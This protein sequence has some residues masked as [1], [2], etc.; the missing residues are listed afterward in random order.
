M[1]EDVKLCPVK[2]AELVEVPLSPI[3]NAAHLE[4]KLHNS[5][6]VE[7]S[8]LFCLREDFNLRT[9]HLPCNFKVI[10]CYVLVHIDNSLFR[11][12]F[13]FNRPTCLHGR[14]GNRVANL[15]ALKFLHDPPNVG[16]ILYK[17]YPPFL[18][19]A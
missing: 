15:L 19:V 13:P 9:L 1:G 10:L 3:Q 8:L 16:T 5:E 14:Y 18:Y 4:E 6:A 17:D 11:E 12:L 2:E 7:D